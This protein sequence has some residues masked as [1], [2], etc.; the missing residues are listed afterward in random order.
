MVCSAVVLGLAWT[1]SA[2]VAGLD[3]GRRL[4]AAM[5]PHPDGAGRD[6]HWASDYLD[7]PGIDVA[8]LHCRGTVRLVIQLGEIWPLDECGEVRPGALPPGVAGSLAVEC[9]IYLPNGMVIRRVS[10]NRGPWRYD[11]MRQGRASHCGTS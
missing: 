10:E 3:T 5:T 7:M 2:C 6:T 9:G 4:G 8:D 1:V 11:L